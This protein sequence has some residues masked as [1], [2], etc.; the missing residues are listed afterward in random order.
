MH[1]LE[2]RESQLNDTLP[3]VEDPDAENKA[4][5]TALLE[6]RLTAESDLSV[7]R[8]MAGE[9]EAKLRQL[10]QARLTQDQTAKGIQS[11][12]ERLRLQDADAAV[13]VETLS[14]EVARRDAV[15]E[16]ECLLQYR[17]ARRRPAEGRLHLSSG[18][19]L[20]RE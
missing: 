6:A 18:E 4:R 10:E 5:L 9:I 8:T 17:T 1:D 20:L 2:S 15:P 3:T 16:E 14:D 19:R 11:D 12:I 13:R 7:Q